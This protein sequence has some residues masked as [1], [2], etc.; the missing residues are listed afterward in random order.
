[1]ITIIVF[2]FFVLTFLIIFLLVFVYF[3]ARIFETIFNNFLFFYDLRMQMILMIQ[4]KV[5]LVESTISLEADLDQSQEV[6]E[7]N[8]DQDRVQRI[9][10]TMRIEK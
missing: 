6:I 7:K 2:S 9:E 1:M 4:E 5:R 3:D 10:K 8:I